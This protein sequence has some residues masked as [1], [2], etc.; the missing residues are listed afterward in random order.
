M[1][2]TSPS[3]DDDM[4]LIVVKTFNG[5]PLEYYELSRLAEALAQPIHQKI[6]LY[7]VFDA[8]NKR[9]ILEATRP[10]FGHKL[11]ME[12]FFNCF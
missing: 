8:E 11:H 12:I 1:P 9:P 10:E 3:K 6:T 2:T 7:Q 5:F 4:W